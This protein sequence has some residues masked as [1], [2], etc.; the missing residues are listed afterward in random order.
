MGGRGVGWAGLG[1]VLHYG[2]NVVYMM[3][4]FGGEGRGGARWRG[5]EGERCYMG[6]RREGEVNGAQ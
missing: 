4:R 3:E 6:G 2:R 1:E 5:K